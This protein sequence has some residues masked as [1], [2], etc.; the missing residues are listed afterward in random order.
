MTLRPAYIV[1][2]LLLGTILAGCYSF[3]G[4]S[5]PAHL[6]SI[7]IPEPDDNSGYG[8]GTVRQDLRTRLINRFRD[9]NSLRVL[10]QSTTDARLEVAISILRDDVRLGINSQEFESDRG[11]LI[12]ARVTFTDNVKRRP[13]YK[14][15]SFVVRS[16][17]PVSGGLES[18]KGAIRD[19]LSKLVDEILVATVADW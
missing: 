2:A 10:D 1:S 12:E 18:R 11:V 9:D 3:R 19:A 4:G 5:V 6:S 14:D 16:Q 7:A 17:Y 8:D 13:I 15:R